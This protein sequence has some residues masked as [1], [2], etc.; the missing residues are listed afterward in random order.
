[1]SS[2]SFSQLELNATVG[3]IRSARE[4]NDFLGVWRAYLALP[5]AQRPDYADLAGV[6]GEEHPGHWPAYDR[7][8]EAAL[9]VRDNLRRCDLVQELVQRASLMWV[10]GGRNF[11]R[12]VF[13]RTFLSDTWTLDKVERP[14]LKT[15]LATL[16]TPR[17]ERVDYAARPP[18]AP[19]QARAW[20]E[21]WDGGW[22]IDLRT[23]GEEGTFNAPVLL[24]DEY[25]RQVVA[26]PFGHD[27]SEALIWSSYHRFSSKVA[28][29]VGDDGRLIATVHRGAWTWPDWEPGAN[30]PLLKMSGPHRTL[31]SS[32]GGRPI[33]SPDA[34]VINYTTVT[35]EIERSNGPIK[36]ARRELLGS[37]FGGRVIMGYHSGGLLQVLSFPATSDESAQGHLERVLGLLRAAQPQLLAGW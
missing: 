24:A 30:L 4:G 6:Y 34:L 28:E 18:H 11:I 13:K 9:E 21:Q 16:S 14:D 19:W 5:V 10:E 1:M 29:I 37:L 23:N 36:E 25:G 31:V 35:R 26:L 7:V 17:P 32:Y 8:A 27:E 2:Q 12:E 15:Q 20:T 22:G 3:N 33:W